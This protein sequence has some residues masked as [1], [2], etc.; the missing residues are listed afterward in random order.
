[1]A[2]IEINVRQMAT[3]AE[4]LR[5]IASRIMPPGDLAAI[6]QVFA[7]AQED[8]SAEEL[9][10]LGKTGKELR[11]QQWAIYTDLMMLA[12]SIGQYGSTR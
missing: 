4:N 8:A 2:A 9:I 11:G 12:D 5:G 3:W 6:D 1:M 7:A 10:E